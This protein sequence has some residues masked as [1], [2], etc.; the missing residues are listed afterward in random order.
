L[1]SLPGQPTACLPAGLDPSNL[2][3]VRAFLNSGEFPSVADGRFRIVYLDETGSAERVR[4]IHGLAGHRK[5]QWFTRCESGVFA[6]D[7]VAPAV[8]RLEYRLG[9]TDADGVETVMNDPRCPCIALD[10]FG[11]KSVVFAQGYAEP[12][13]IQPPP[14]EAV[15]DL[16]EIMLPGLGDHHW[17][18]WVWTPPGDRLDQVLPLLMIL[19]G[20]DYIRFVR[21]RNILENLTHAGGGGGLLPRVRAV[22]MRP[23]HRDAE[24][25]AN[26]AMPELLT[27]LIPEALSDRIPVPAD[28][29]KRF[30]IGTSLGGLCLLH[31]H[32]NQPEF[33]GGLLLQSGSFF[34]PRSDA[35]ENTFGFFARI[36]DFVQRVASSSN[37]QFRDRHIP[38]QMTCGRGG[39]NLTNNRLM[40]AML[41]E[42]GYPIEL[43]EW[44]DAHNWTSWRDCIGP[45]LVNL[46]APLAPVRPPSSLT[47]DSVR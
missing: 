1:E 33:F 13:Y 23:N 17:T 31:T 46:L 41:K 35:M 7:F 45:R 34:Q 43:T 42:R 47:I 10:P 6:M 32:M 28:A 5:P 12:L 22:F 8:H 24:Y 38:I 15:G 25:S 39:E 21:M 19:D 11:G 3:S 30:A 29:S 27:K 44:P 18:S 4:L 9:V 37:T 14:R 36:T 20:S 16:T 26:P 2:D 40:A